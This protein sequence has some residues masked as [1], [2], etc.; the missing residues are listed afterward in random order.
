MQ[1]SDEVKLLQ[2]KLDKALAKLEQIEQHEDA[3]TSSAGIESE[4][5]GC[6]TCMIS[7]LFAA[8]HCAYCPL[9]RLAIGKYNAGSCG[10]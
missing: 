4:S 2:H 6:F 7:V 1:E 10:Y 9:N 3:V 8:C 5:P